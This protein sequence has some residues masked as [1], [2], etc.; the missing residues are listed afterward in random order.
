MFAI[1]STSRTS[2]LGAQAQQRPCQPVGESS[3]ASHFELAFTIT[4]FERFVGPHIWR[5]REAVF[6]PL[7]RLLAARN[8]PRK[9]RFLAHTHFFHA[10][11]KFPRVTNVEPVQPPMRGF[12]HDRRSDDFR[13]R[14]KDESRIDDAP[15]QGRN[16][17]CCAAGKQMRPKAIEFLEDPTVSVWIV[18][19]Y[20]LERLTE[21]MQNLLAALVA[22]LSNPQAINPRA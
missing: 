9:G 6:D 14:G 19:L 21:A 7:P 11:T 5:V 18:H 2:P 4:L 17:A 20:E 15:S 3:E 16:E 8:F 12:M 13:P 22:K 10:R 1:S